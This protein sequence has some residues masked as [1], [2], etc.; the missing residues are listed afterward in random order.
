M[1]G[2]EKITNVPT[3]PS[4][5]LYNKTDGLYNAYSAYNYSTESIAKGDFIRLKEVSLSYDVDKKFAKKFGLSSLS[6]KA[7]ATNIMLL[8]S[9]KKLNGQDPEFVTAG[10][11]AF[12][13]PKQYTFT[14]KMSF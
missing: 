1:P 10:G 9:D 6:L 7:Q 14:L 13:N 11:V 4:A 2:D 12:P 8:Y 5:E 3:I